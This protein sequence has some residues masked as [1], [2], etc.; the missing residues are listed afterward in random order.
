[1]INAGKFKVLLLGGTG[2]ARELASLLS[3]DQR[4]ETLLSLAGRTENPL[5]QK[6]VTR[7]GGFGG[8]EGLA[9]Y[10]RAEKFD[11]LIDGTHPFASQMTSNAAKAAT[12]TQIPTL[13]ILRPEWRPE[14]AEAWST[15]P[16]VDEAVA[17]LPS[18]ARVFSA[19]GRGSFVNYTARTDIY[20]LLRVIDPQ[21]ERFPGNG[22]FVV[23]RPPFTVEAEERQLSSVRATHLLVKNAGGEP[24]RTKLTA[25]ANLGIPIL[26][27]NRPPFPENVTSVADARSAQEWINSLVA[28]A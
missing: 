21:S 3:K 10:I 19:T 14:G 24:A 6:V 9:D 22:E 4:L 12:M 15:F 8:P 13:H 11:C 28:S 20:T 5:D 26:V 7:I 27:V 17:E 18:G 25:A 2:E 23:A 16:S 1:M